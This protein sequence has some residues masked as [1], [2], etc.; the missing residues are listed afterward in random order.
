MFFTSYVKFQFD[1][2]LLIRRH[3]IECANAPLTLMWSPKEIVVLANAINSKWGQK[4]VIRCPSEL[5][6]A[7]RAS[8]DNS[9]NNLQLE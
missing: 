7:L 4:I 9:V 1:S 8:N 3:L 6:P 2:P 5:E